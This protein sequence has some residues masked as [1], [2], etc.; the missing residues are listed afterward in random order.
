MFFDTCFYYHFFQVPY[1]LSYTFLLN[2]FP[3]FCLFIFVVVCNSSN[4]E[5]SLPQKTSQLCVSFINLIVKGL[6]FSHADG[7]GLLVI[8]KLSLIFNIV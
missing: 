3:S 1:S 2:T 8:F 4:T 7:Q 5:K 6:M